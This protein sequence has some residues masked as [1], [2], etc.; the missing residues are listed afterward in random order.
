MISN[1]IS[2]SK[3]RV[4]LHPPYPQT[5][6]PQHEER[7]DVQSTIY[8][9]MLAPNLR[10]IQGVTRT[11]AHA[12]MPRAM[13]PT[14]LDWTTCA[15]RDGASHLPRID[16]LQ[17]S[18]Q[19]LSLEAYVTSISTPDPL[20]MPGPIY[21]PYRDAASQVEQARCAS[22]RQHWCWGSAPKGNTVRHKSMVVESK[23]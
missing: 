12:V 6:D 10:E 15:L 3:V 16:T 5:S 20:R 2:G 18:S 7:P 1:M 22:S 17:R 19:N 9:L 11:R 13:A 23:A 4:L 14:P 21:A 8:R